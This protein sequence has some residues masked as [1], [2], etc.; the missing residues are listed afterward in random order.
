MEKNERIELAEL[1]FPNI[2]KARDYYEKLYPER[3][4]KENAMVTRYGPSPTGS[5]HLG[6]LLSAFADMVYARQSGGSFFLR[7]EDTDQKRMMMEAL[8]I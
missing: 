3:K 8:K 1:L 6:N 4:L 7:I 2:D 5:V